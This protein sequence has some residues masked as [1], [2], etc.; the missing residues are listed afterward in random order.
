MNPTDRIG[1]RFQNQISKPGNEVFLDSVDCTIGSGIGITIPSAE[2]R[3]DRYRKSTPARKRIDFA[4]LLSTPSTWWVIS[5]C[6]GVRG[7]SSSSS[8]VVSHSHPH[9]S[10]SLPPANPRQSTPS[11]GPTPIGDPAAAIGVPY[12]RPSR[13]IKMTMP[14]A[15]LHNH[16]G[17]TGDVRE[18]TREHTANTRAFSE[19]AHPTAMGP[20]LRFIRMGVL[21]VIGYRQNTEPACTQK[22][23]LVNPSL[24]AATVN[25]WAIIRLN[26]GSNQVL[27][28]STGC[29]PLDPA[30][31]AGQM[32]QSPGRKKDPC[33]HQS[34]P[35][36]HC[37]IRADGCSSNTQ[38]PTSGQWETPRPQ[39]TVNGFSRPLLCHRQRHRR[40][41]SSNPSWDD[42]STRACRLPHSSGQTISRLANPRRTPQRHDD[43]RS[44]LNRVSK[45]PL[46]AFIADAGHTLALHKRPPPPPPGPGGSKYGWDW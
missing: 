43:V 37:I 42:P 30:A 24:S 27:S 14:I 2:K 15:A 33:R 32:V 6:P 11:A 17:V 41:S 26:Q 46:P 21:R 31:G 22:S 29:R 13:R 9:T 19:R 35:K 20:C 16:V 38:H 28:V 18:G 5:V 25:A 39:K 45:I 10:C 3:S 8:R 7:G 44:S 4:L 36:E 1:S 23:G 34:D 40:A 12:C